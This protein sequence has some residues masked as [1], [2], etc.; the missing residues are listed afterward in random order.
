MGLCASTMLLV[1][2]WW[3][4]HTKSR[5]RKRGGWGAWFFAAQMTNK[6]KKDVP[7]AQR[8]H[9]I[10]FE[11]D[12]CGSGDDIKNQRGQSCFGAK[13]YLFATGVEHCANH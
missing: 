10:F 12:D 5:S 6:A 9:P 2:C 13:I 1:V 4:A 11:K 8:E 3:V 7:K